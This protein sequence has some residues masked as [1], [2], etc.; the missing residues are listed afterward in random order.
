MYIVHIRILKKNL[1]FLINLKIKYSFVRF[2]LYLNKGII[3]FVYLLNKN[4]NVKIFY[5]QRIWL[6]IRFIFFSCFGGHKDLVLSLYC[7]WHVRTFFISKI[8]WRNNIISYLY[9]QKQYINSGYGCN[10]KI[11]IYNLR[12]GF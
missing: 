9:F 3:S 12:N 6:R 4:N 8:Q 1:K 10:F 11:N 5:K 2:Y 7:V